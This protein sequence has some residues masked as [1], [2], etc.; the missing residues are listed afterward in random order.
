ME[1]RIYGVTEL[2]KLRQDNETLATPDYKTTSQRDN[3]SGGSLNYGI[4]DLR[5][6]GI[7]EALPIQRVVRSLPIANSQRPTDL[8]I[9][10]ITKYY[11]I[12]TLQKDIYRQTHSY[13]AKELINQHSFY[14]FCIYTYYMQTTILFQNSINLFPN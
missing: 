5:N 11:Y 14:K 7:T 2:W 8:S 4:T 12:T 1:L 13:L 3:E 9:H 10:Y 6:Y